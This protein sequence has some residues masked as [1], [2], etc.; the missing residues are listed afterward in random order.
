[1]LRLF[2]QAMSSK[3]EDEIRELEQEIARIND[4]ILETNQRNSQVTDLCQKLIAKNDTKSLRIQTESCRARFLTLKGIVR[5]RPR[6]QKPHR[7][8]YS[9]SG[10]YPESSASL[11]FEICNDSSIR[12]CQAKLDSAAFRHRESS[13]ARLS[14]SAASYL[15]TS[16][17]DLFKRLS[18][19][20]KS[21]FEIG[22]AMVT[23]DWQVGRLE[24]LAE[25][26]TALEARQATQ[27]LVADGKTSLTMEIAGVL[28]TIEFDGMYP[29]KRTA[30]IDVLKEGKQFNVQGLRLHVVRQAKPG[31]QY[32]TRV[33]D[34]IKAY[35]HGQRF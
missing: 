12:M 2:A 6:E 32:L 1:M 19:T 5:W 22:P 3:L 24:H 28:V 25:E 35:L 17:E 21:L 10:C 23:L 14:R 30:R 33:Y 31:H 15:K 26:I 18:A 4:N 13:K 27:F 29:F 20:T 7:L 11:R 9:F 34:C 16:V 8:E